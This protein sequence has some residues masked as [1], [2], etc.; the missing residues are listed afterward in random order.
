MKHFVVS[1]EEKVVEFEGHRIQNINA[2]LHEKLSEAY[3]DRE[4][5]FLLCE[6]HEKA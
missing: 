4:E 1:A 2:N 3:A 5:S 6:N